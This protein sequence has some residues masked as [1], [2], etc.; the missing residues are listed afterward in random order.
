MLSRIVGTCGCM[1]ALVSPAVAVAQSLLVASPAVVINDRTRTAPLVLINDGVEA[2]EATVSTF[3]GYPVTDSTGRMYLR[4]FAGSADTAPSAAGWVESFPKRLR[5]APKSR[6]TVRLLVNPPAGL[7]PGE[8]WSRLMVSARGGH[9][10][11]A[12]IADSLG[13]VAKLDLEVR[14]VI[15]L[16]YRVGTPATGVTMSGLRSWR[17]GDSLTARVLLTRT[18]NAAFVGAVRARLVD[19]KGVTRSETL[20]PVGVYYDLEPLVGLPLAGVPPGH[21]TLRLETVAHRPDV[22]PELLLPAASARDS[23]PVDIK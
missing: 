11:V 15:A 4:T 16:F 14:S 5:I 12:G 19:A 8:Y 10:P 13:V 3:F 23:L 17:T 22:L 18:G 1:A 9:A 7:K 6:A 21:Y 20:L 2:V